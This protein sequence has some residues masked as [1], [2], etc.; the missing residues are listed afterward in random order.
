MQIGSSAVGFCY[1]EH[2][3]TVSLEASAHY[4]VRLVQMALLL[5]GL[6]LLVP[7][8]VGTANTE[9]E[10]RQYL[11]NVNFSSILST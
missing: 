1:R 8:Y 10:S 5:L 7:C 11:N 6:S 4:Y 3:V 2:T 9:E